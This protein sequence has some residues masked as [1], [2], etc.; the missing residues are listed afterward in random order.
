MKKQ[1]LELKNVALYVHF[2]NL[3]VRS[4]CGDHYGVLTL[5]FIDISEGVDKIRYWDNYSFTGK[6][7]RNLTFRGQWER[8]QREKGVYG[9]RLSL[10]MNDDVERV[11]DAL[12]ILDIMKRIEKARW[13]LP[14]EP[15]TF[16]QF[17]ALMCQSIGVK[18]FV[19]R[20]DKRDGH[21]WSNIDSYYHRSAKIDSYLVRMIDNKIEETYFA[22]EK[23]ADI[24]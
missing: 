21:F 19:C 24:A 13:N 9:Q 7:F 6:R 3:D 20:T 22:A 16:G 17:V 12:A 2:D 10:H 11:E 1:A 8:D 23:S 14:I 18:T 5:R 15:N 4:S